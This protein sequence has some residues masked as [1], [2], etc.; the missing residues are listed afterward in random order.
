MSQADVGAELAL[1]R[2][3]VLGLQQREDERT[4]AWK[5][6]LKFVRFS[7]V[8]FSVAALGVLLH[9][10]ITNRNSIPE[11]GIEL[12]LL[13]IPLIILGQALRAVVG[14]SDAKG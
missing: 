7:V 11:A 6:S 10:W 12:I 2:D 5:S 8:G 14:A 4:K 3:Q 13:N 9:A 1:L